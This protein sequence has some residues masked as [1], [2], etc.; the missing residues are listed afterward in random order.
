MDV[1][2]AV[3]RIA[4]SNQ[5][6]FYTAAKQKRGAKLDKLITI[7]KHVSIVKFVNFSLNNY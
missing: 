2:K 4:Y 5:K 7:K 1:L 6:M 3:L